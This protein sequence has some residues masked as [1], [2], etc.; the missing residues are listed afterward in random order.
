MRGTVADLKR[1]Y[2]GTIAHAPMTANL[3][4]ALEPS[5][6]PPIWLMKAD[7]DPYAPDSLGDLFR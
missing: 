4:V 5:L 7:G 2:T 1:S 3:L 6:G